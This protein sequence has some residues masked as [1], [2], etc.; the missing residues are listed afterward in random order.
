MA[1]IEYTGPHAEVDVLDPLGGTRTVAR[2]GTLGT[3]DRH[4]AKLLRQPAN[5]RRPKREGKDGV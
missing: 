5:W 4:A 3:T 2:G 1:K